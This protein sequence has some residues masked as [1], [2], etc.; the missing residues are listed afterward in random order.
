MTQSDMS[1]KAVEDFVESFLLTR[2]S[3]QCRKK[4]LREGNTTAVFR[5]SECE[6]ES[7]LRPIGMRVPKPKKH[8]AD[9]CEV[10]KDCGQPYTAFR[11]NVSENACG[12]ADD[13]K[14]LATF[15]D[16]FISLSD[17][18]KLFNVMRS[19]RK[20]LS[21]NWFQCTW[22]TPYCPTRSKMEATREYTYSQQYCTLHQVILVYYTR[23]KPS[24]ETTVLC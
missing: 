23:R 8:Y 17:E 11:P 21:P 16:K 6:C 15:S 24:S 14:S 9:R 4:R 18:I 20:H 19:T 5:T 12:Y 22:K 7:A 13:G 10:R 1:V 3:A 2:S